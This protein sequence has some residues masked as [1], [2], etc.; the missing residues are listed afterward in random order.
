MPCIQ[1]IPGYLLA[2][3]TQRPG[4]PAFVPVTRSVTFNWKWL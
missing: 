1:L 3:I 4:E 2:A